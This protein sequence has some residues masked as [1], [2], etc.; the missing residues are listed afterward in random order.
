[1]IITKDELNKLIK[2][3]NKLFKYKKHKSL[4]DKACTLCT[5][6]ENIIQREYNR[7]KNPYKEY[8]CTHCG[9]INV[10]KEEIEE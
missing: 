5:I 10:L 4:Y 6:I 3:E 9:K 1:M 2:L 7:K 8:H